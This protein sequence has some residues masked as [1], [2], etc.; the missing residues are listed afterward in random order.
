VI[1]PGIAVDAAALRGKS[2]QD[3]QATAAAGAAEA[4]RLKIESLD[5]HKKGLAYESARYLTLLQI[6][7]LWKDHMKK[8]DYVKDFAGMKIYDNKKPLD[9]YRIEGL[10]EF[11]KMEAALRQN[12][13]FS[14]FS[15]RPV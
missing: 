14:F 3:A 5:A 4:L 2:L 7:N 9:V 10:E 11:K 8:M 1:F 12:T 15:Y 6:D 13:I